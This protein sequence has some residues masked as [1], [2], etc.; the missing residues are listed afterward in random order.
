MINENVKELKELTVYKPFY[1][2]NLVCMDALLELYIDDYDSFEHSSETGKIDP[3]Q[4]S[5]ESPTL[6]NSMKQTTIDL[7]K[8]FSTNTKE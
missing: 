1:L 4:G 6:F 5:V 7:S 3:N 2:D 8:A